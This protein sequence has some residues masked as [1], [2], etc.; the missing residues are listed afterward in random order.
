MHPG[1]WYKAGQYST[2]VM[3]GVY[4]PHCL[5]ESTNSAT[6]I[7]RSAKVSK[8]HKQ[9]NT[10]RTIRQAACPIRHAARAAQKNYIACSP[11][12]FHD[13]FLCADFRDRHKYSCTQHLMHLKPSPSEGTAHELA[14]CKVT[15]RVCLQHQLSRTKCH[16]INSHSLA[17]A[18][19]SALA[20][21]EFCGCNIGRQQQ[22]LSRQLE[23]ITP[24]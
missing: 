20:L 14:F 1:S 10:I 11:L 6:G 19:R 16:S 5:P 22:R 2:G 9:L 12:H 17:A 15:L 8:M 24:R 21:Q 23:V 7:G 3:A 4:V 18:H 13:A